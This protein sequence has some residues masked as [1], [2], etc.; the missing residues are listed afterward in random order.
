MLGKVRKLALGY[1]DPL[2]P[3][4]V[5]LDGFSE[6][7]LSYSG[8]FEDNEDDIRYYVVT[9]L[10]SNEDIVNDRT[11]PIIRQIGAISEYEGEEVVSRYVDCPNKDGWCVVKEEYCDGHTPTPMY[12]FDLDETLNDGI[13]VYTREQVAKRHTVVNGCDS[14][15]VISDLPHKAFQKLQYVSHNS[16][17]SFTDHIPKLDRRYGNIKGFSVYESDCLSPLC[18]TD[19]NYYCLSHAALE[20]MRKEKRN[21]S[22]SS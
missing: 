22:T 6:I 2:H 11:I 15:Y 10:V 12:C 9:V 4:K 5:M 14:L 19:V 13:Y 18:N 17:V 8:E 16:L 20:L 3:D 1:I 7:K 21:A